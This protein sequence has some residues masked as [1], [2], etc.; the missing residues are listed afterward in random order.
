M[1]RGMEPAR[2]NGKALIMAAAIISAVLG[3]LFGVACIATP[4]LVRERH[5]RPDYDDTV[6]YFKETGRSAQEIAR[7]N[8][9][10]QSQQSQ[11]KNV[12]QARKASG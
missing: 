10:L 5:Q 12:A 2:G 3:L 7:G 8:A 9:A 11:Q 1:Q 6:A 4:Q